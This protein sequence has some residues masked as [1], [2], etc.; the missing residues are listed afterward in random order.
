LSIDF[1]TDNLTLSGQT[2]NGGAFFEAAKQSGSWGFAFGAAVATGWTFGEISSSLSVMDFLV[3]QDAY[4]LIS[5]FTQKQYTFPNFALMTTP[6]NVV[7]GL[8]LGGVINFAAGT[9]TLAQI[10]THWSVRAPRRCRVR[11]ARW[12]TP[13]FQRRSA[14]R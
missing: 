12:P 6:I 5:T 2:A 7:P 3:F 4:L 13:R 14:D 9:S 11:S 1:S 8:N 10:A